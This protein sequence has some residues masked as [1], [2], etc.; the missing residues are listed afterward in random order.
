MKVTFLGTGTSSGVPIPTCACRVCTSDDPRDRRLRPSVYLEWYGA[1]VLIDAAS[2]FREQALTHKIERVDAVLFTHAHA[3]HVLGIDDLRIFNWRQGGAIPAYGTALT[4]ENVARMFWYVF[5]TKK[6]ENTRPAIERRTIERQPFSLLGREIQPIPAMH[7]TL[8]ILGY[9][10]GSFAYLTDVSDLP[11]ES[12]RLLDGLDHLVLNALRP[13][14][15]PT[16]LSIDQAVALA[17]IVGA[18]QTWF[19]HMSHEVLHAEVQA[20]L[21]PG[22]ELAYDGLVLEL[23][24]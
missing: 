19:T 7:G 22:V 10:V 15:H 18:K 17:R 4:L 14:P 11:E 20:E 6:S 2:D 12:V 9:R 3:D 1:G 13:R 23:S 21:P 24:D 8:P 5:D 16:H